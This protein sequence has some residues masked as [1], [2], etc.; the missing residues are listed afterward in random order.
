MREVDTPGLEKLF[1]M[2]SKDEGQPLTPNL[3]MT[4]LQGEYVDPVEQGK[5][6]SEL[7]DKKFDD[8]EDLLV[9]KLTV[10]LIINS[11]QNESTENDQ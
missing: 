11:E 3:M 9:N 1:G 7:S 6:W 8:L 4:Q 10:E 5:A 2:S